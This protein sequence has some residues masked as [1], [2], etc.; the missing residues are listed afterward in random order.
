MFAVLSVDV[1]PGSPVLMVAEFH[2]PTLQDGARSLVLNL[3]A[4]IASR[5]PAHE[6][7]GRRFWWVVG[8]A[9]LFC[10]L[11]VLRCACGEEAAK[12]PTVQAVAPESGPVAA[13]ELAP[14]PV[15]A[16]EP[17]RAPALEASESAIPD[18]YAPHAEILRNDPDH[19]AR[20]ISAKKII[21][22]IESDKPKIP[23]YIRNLAWLEN[24]SGC[25]AKKAVLAKIE[26]DNDHHVVP[27]LRILA[28]TPRNGCRKFFRRY[29][30]LG[31]LREDL[32]RVLGRFEANYPE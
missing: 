12:P 24:G 2:A 29:D 17:T 19:K 31:C 9:A 25:E 7:F 26:A 23:Q 6:G 28:A 27:A 15:P 18:A 4:A 5:L 1:E 10:F 30:C 3:R 14:A 22:A 32:M 13:P 21:A 20:K 16:R 8:G 11:L